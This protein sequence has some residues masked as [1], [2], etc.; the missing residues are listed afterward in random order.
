MRS[1]DPQEIAVVIS[2]RLCPDLI[3]AVI[4]IS[5]VWALGTSQAGL[6][7]WQLAER[8]GKLNAS[9]MPPSK[10]RKLGSQ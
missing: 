10:I 6:K 7:V 2:L 1:I 3:A 9:G 5:K 4:G 8:S